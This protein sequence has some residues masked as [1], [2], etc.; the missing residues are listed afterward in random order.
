MP[1]LIT[2]SYCRSGN[3]RWISIGKKTKRSACY[4]W[5]IFRPPILL[6]VPSKRMKKFFSEKY[7]RQQILT[8][9]SKFENCPDFGKKPSVQ[10]G[11]TH[12]YEIISFGA[13]STANLPPSTILEKIKFFPKTQIS[14][15]LRKLTISV[16]FYGKLPWFGEKSF[17]DQENWT[18]G[19]YQFPNSVKRCLIS[20][21]ERI[22]FLRYYKYGWEVI[23]TSKS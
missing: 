10:V 3:S 2:R 9:F 18:F 19:H 21:F 22:N 14:Y 13:H 23:L 15:D 20:F 1:L 8:L 5:Q 6:K 11:K 16:A 7:Y 17:R 12:F 4:H